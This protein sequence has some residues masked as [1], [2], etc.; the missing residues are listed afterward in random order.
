MQEQT[1]RKTTAG[2]DY[3]RGSIVSDQQLIGRRWAA[4]TLRFSARGKT[5]RQFGNHRSV[6]RGRGL[7]F[8]EL[9][10]Y[11]AGDEIRHIDWKVTA[12]TGKPHTKLFQEERERPGM[13]AVD[14][15]SC[16]YF[17]SRYCFKSV[18]AAEIAATLAWAGLQR[19]D[20][21]GGLVFNEQQ[22]SEIRPRRQRRS[23]LSL[24]HKLG[25]YNRALQ[26]TEH[27]QDAGL[28]NAIAELRRLV[29]PGSTCFLITDMRG[30]QDDDLRHLRQIARHSDVVII[31]ISDPL[32][33]Q[34]PMAMDVKFTDGQSQLAINP[35]KTL[36][37]RF[38]KAAEQQ[39]KD[40]SLFAL[41][42]GASIIHLRTD[43]LW[44]QRLQQEL[45]L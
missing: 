5:A 3:A 34:L 19:G 31:R 20:R 11:Q 17:G 26:Q 21:V 2:G 36:I 33:Q 23:V 4:A 25:E 14:Q 44:L 35:N 39:S 28:S 18:L 30:F 41:S 40:W 29:K 32:E 1:D 8:Q 9:R 13:I 15:R 22:H 12:R 16:M 7:E 38:A 45:L 24:I 42:A 43:E 6:L 10:E 37:D 27:W